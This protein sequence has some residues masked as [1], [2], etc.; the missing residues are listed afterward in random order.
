MTVI[1][2]SSPQTIQIVS[3][4]LSNFAIIDTATLTSKI[5]CCDTVYSVEILVGDVTAN[6][7]TIDNEEF[8]GDAD[9]NDGIYSFTLTVEY[10]DGSAITQELGCLFV[11]EDTACLVADKISGNV[12]VNTYEG[13]QTLLLE[14]DYF[15]LKNAAN[16]CPCECNDFCAILERVWKAVDKIDCDICVTTCTEC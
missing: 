13:Q 5:N 15:F 3:T 9:L 16:G 8:Y 14:M 1:Y 2:T 6:T 11:D 10:N 7:Y 4:N 12:D